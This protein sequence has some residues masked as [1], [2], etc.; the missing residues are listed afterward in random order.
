MIIDEEPL[1]TA[2]AQ[3]G[4]NLRAMLAKSLEKANAAGK[5]VSISSPPT[6]PLPL[7]PKPGAGGKAPMPTPPPMSAESNE[8]DQEDYT[9]MDAPERP[10]LDT[11][12][13]LYLDM[14]RQPDQSGGAEP[15]SDDF[16]T[17]MSTL[18]SPP[19][20]QSQPAAT[21]G[22]DE[23]Y[24]DMETTAGQLG[25]PPKGEKPR[26]EGDADSFGSQ[27]EYTQ[28]DSSN[29]QEDLYQETDEALTTPRPV[30]TLPSPRTAPP[31]T[32]K[33]R[34]ATMPVQG[35]EEGNADDDPYQLAPNV[36]PVPANSIVQTA[37]QQ[38]FL[39][40]MGGAT[41]KSWQKRYV[42][43]HD[44]TL[45]FY[46]SGKDKRQRNQI[47]L[48]GY[49][50][51]EATEYS[52]KKKPA[53]KLAPGQAPSKGKKLKKIYYFRA[54]SNEERSQWIGALRAALMSANRRSKSFLDPVA[55]EGP[56]DP[57]DSNP[58]GV[59]A[60]IEDESFY[61]DPLTSQ[62]SARQSSMPPAQEE[63]L[64]PNEQL[65][66]SS[67]GTTTS[68]TSSHGQ[69]QDEYLVPEDLNRPAS[70]FNPYAS[71][72][73]AVKSEPLPP[74][75]AAA[76]S[77]PY[78]SRQQA[79][80]D[81]MSRKQLQKLPPT[82]EQNPYASRKQLTSLPPIPPPVAPV[83][84]IAPGSK[85]YVDTKSIYIQKLDKPS[86]ESIYV[87]L[88]DY[89]ASASDELSFKRGELI[90]IEDRLN[91]LD[92]WVGVKKTSNDIEDFSGD[93]G[94]LVSAYVSPAY[95]KLI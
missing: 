32:E 13:S 9:E 5:R 66:G 68:N 27:E 11:S 84:P 41:G 44:L 40:K 28:M 21:A 45:Y 18:Q 48:M 89:N 42:V 29:L 57:M 87:A 30:D 35:Q 33:A 54:N 56:L 16:Y 86:F 62:A 24:T 17:D 94:L 73:Q 49:I 37:G 88:W 1:S 39:E 74:A 6:T 92:W 34:A 79:M 46:H 95:E 58:S 26:K 50:V 51:S 63:Y 23:F 76:S 8:I 90:L 3:K 81:Y 25:L 91:N 2:A 83:A 7:P 70:T 22:D 69:P 38:G 4:K 47:A 77:N 15:V 85:E 20:G 60:G 67:T 59:H 52:T 61:E 19:P 80:S 31:N 36:K 78:A 64:V 72:Q 71:R 65:S 10:R 43:L 55:V 82:P 93:R 75:P 53:F 14:S 12:A